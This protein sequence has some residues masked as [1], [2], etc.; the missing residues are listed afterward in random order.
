MHMVK[1]LVKL[2]KC[3]ILG[4]QSTLIIGDII[5]GEVFFRGWFF[6][7]Y[8]FLIK[9]FIERKRGRRGGSNQ[10]FTVNYS[11]IQL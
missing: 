10:V 7:Y 3:V 1:W 4:P 2:P 5:W 6:S 11:Y 8:S 9:H